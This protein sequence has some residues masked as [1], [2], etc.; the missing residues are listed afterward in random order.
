MTSQPVEKVMD[1]SDVE[2]M[3]AS[4]RPNDEIGGYMHLLSGGEMIELCRTWLAVQDA[5]VAIIR[6][7]WREAASI[8]YDGYSREQVGQVVRLVA[9]GEADHG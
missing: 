9:A 5:P 7:G 6:A 3:L 8:S 1:R 2:S 4:A